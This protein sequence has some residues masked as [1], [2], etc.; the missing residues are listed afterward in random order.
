MSEGQKMKG[1]KNNRKKTFMQV[2]DTNKLQISSLR[3]ILSQ[4]Y[5]T[6]ITK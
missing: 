1:N 5:L 6:Q 2:T 3:M 4:I